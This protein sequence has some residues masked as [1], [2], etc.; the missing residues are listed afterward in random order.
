MYGHPDL[1][2][3]IFDPERQPAAPVPEPAKPAD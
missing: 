1:V 3:A 2:A